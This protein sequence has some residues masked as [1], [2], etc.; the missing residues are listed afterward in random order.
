MGARVQVLSSRN[1][2]SSCHLCHGT[3]YA[4][5]V[6]QYLD[7]FVVHCVGTHDENFRRCSCFKEAAADAGTARA[8]DCRGA[9]SGEALA[10]QGQRAWKKDCMHGLTCAPVFLQWSDNLAPAK[11]RE[12]GRPASACACDGPCTIKCVTP[13]GVAHVARNSCRLIRRRCRAYS[14]TARVG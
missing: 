1:R 4:A 10:C 7:I 6:S 5:C 2:K 11:L 8:Q 13:P 14:M 9:H 3:D 12:G